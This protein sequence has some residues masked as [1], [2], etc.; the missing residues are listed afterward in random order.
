MNDADGNLLYYEGFIT[1]ITERMQAEEDNRRMVERWSIVYRAGEEIGASLD[2]GQIFAAVH[3]AVK[4][5]MPCEDFVISLYDEIHNKMGGETILSKT[6]KRLH[7][8]PIWLIMGWEV[9]LFDPVKKS[10]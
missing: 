7:L 9:I 5:V 8:H 1:D 4:Q 3:R 10:Y 6:I 2:T